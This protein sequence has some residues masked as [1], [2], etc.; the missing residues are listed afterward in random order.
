MVETGLN[1]Q[2]DDLADAV[3]SPSRQLITLRVSLQHGGS[4]ASR[5]TRPLSS[6]CQRTMRSLGPWHFLIHASSAPQRPPI[7][8]DLTCRSLIHRHGLISLNALFDDAGTEY[9]VGPEEWSAVQRLSKGTTACCQ[10]KSSVVRVRCL[11]AFQLCLL[12]N[13]ENSISR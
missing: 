5:P 13:G 10:S 7:I 4:A 11:Q 9:V 6:L 3:K 8:V 2:G 12:L 1:V